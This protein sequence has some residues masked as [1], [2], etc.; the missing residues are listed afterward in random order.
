MSKI[1]RVALCLAAIVLVS[2]TLVTAPAEAACRPAYIIAFDESHC[3]NYCHARG[4]NYSYDPDFG[5]CA[6]S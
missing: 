3:A 1:H 6:C 2:L 5:D 4:C